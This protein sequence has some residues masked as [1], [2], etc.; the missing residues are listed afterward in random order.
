MIPLNDLGRHTAALSG[1]IEAAL[2]RVASSGWFLM[3]QE[4]AAF[5]REFAAWC[6]AP[7]CVGVANGTEALEIAMRAL[8]VGPGSRV[9]TV[10][11]AG[12][13]GTVAMLA[14]GARPVFV[15]VDRESML[16][17]PAALELTDLSGVSAII[18]THLYGQLADMGP[19]LELASKRGIPVIEDCA[20]SHGA[21][22]GGRAAGAYGALAC[23][24]FY[25]TKNLGAMGDGGAITGSDEALV[26]RVRQL[27]QY[28]W[29]SKYVSTLAGG[30]N[31]RL[32]E[33]QAAV[34]RVKLP[35]V[36]AWNAR[37]REIGARYASGIRHPQVRVARRLD[38]SDVVHLFVVRCANRASLSAHCKAHGVGT[39]IHYPVPDHRQPMMGEG[40]AAASL[41][42][43]ERACAEVLTLPCFPEMSDAE[44]ATVIDVV[45]AWT[46]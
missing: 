17:D 29:A 7:H 3:G 9:A 35:H 12:T 27:R 30:R 1:D 43:T 16:M 41:P 39:D 18:A 38:E 13:Y 44:V 45:N 23:F 25:P 24:S 36:H 26:G 8:G 37:R 15:D 28:G 20:Q 14:I 32:D 22:R 42:E 19:I 46:S 6:G 5:E 40:A 31:S 4:L 21:M 11:N 34:L 2:A 33:M 10:A